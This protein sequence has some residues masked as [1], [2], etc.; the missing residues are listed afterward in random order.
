MKTSHQFAALRHLQQEDEEALA[1]THS[2]C[3]KVTTVDLKQS[4]HEHLAST[5]HILVFVCFFFA[6]SNHFLPFFFDENSTV[7]ENLG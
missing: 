2:S 1:P 5:S 6:G 7:S 4:Q 3:Y